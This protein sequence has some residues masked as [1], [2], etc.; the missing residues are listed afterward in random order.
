MKTYARIVAGVVVELIRLSGTLN[1][2]TTFASGI[3]LNDVTS[4]S[5]QP[6]VGWLYASGAYAA[7]AAPAAL[8]PKQAAKAA[9]MAGCQIVSA[10]MSAISTTYPLT[11]AALNGMART[12]Q[13]I[14]LNGNA[15]PAGTAAVSLVDKGGTARSITTAAEFL[16]L[17]QAL[18]AYA[19]A[20]DQ[21]VIAN[22]GAL[23]VQPV[24][25]A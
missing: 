8:S 22:S 13:L 11:E 1:V 23:P 18:A 17:Y 10:G 7:P 12:A 4:L 14:T 25:I 20:L 19:L 6:A 21:I 16:V 3:V 5:P 2:A 9:R 24:D 15:F